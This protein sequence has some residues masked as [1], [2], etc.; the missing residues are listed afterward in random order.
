[1]IMEF[2][3]RT[4]RFFFFLH[5]VNNLNLVLTIRRGAATICGLLKEVFFSK[6]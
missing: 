1:M 2:I 4:N 6:Q 5:F 3:D